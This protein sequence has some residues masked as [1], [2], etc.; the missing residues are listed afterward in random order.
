[1]THLRD[2]PKNAPPKNYAYISPTLNWT[3]HAINSM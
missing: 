1:M 2:Q 3:K